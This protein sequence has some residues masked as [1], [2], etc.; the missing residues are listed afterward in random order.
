MTEMRS[1][2]QESAED[3]FFGQ[4]VI[5]WARWFVIV[6][7]VV[8]ILWTSTNAAELTVA[9]LM[10]VPLIAANF[11]VHGRYMME[12]PIN[13]NLLLGLSLVDIIVITLIVL[14]WRGD[15]GFTSPYYIFYY[16]ILLA[17]SFVFPVRISIPYLVVTIIAYTAA[18]LVS[19]FGMLSRSYQI[20][21]MIIRMITMG[22]VGGVA[23][24]Y[25]RIQ[26]GRRRVASGASKPAPVGS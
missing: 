11:F 5:I 12:R 23:G 2:A 26:R 25:W 8:V 4:L 17:F 14:L 15:N 13:Q 24:V 16:P 21:G 9:V 7:G 1:A 22:A 10:I 6:T 18:C 3:I 20:E 19:D